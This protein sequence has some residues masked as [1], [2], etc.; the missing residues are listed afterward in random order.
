MFKM[1]IS[2]MM[3]MFFITGCKLAVDD[4]K[5]DTD[6]STQGGLTDSNNYTE[7]QGQIYYQLDEIINAQE[8]D[9]MSG[10]EYKLL[11]LR[12]YLIGKSHV[13]RVYPDLDGN[14]FAY[15]VDAGSYQVVIKWTKTKYDDTGAEY[16]Y[17]AIKNIYVVA[18][19][20]TDAGIFY[21]NKTYMTTSE[22][23]SAI[24]DIDTAE[25]S[26][27][28]WAGDDATREELQKM[29]SDSLSQE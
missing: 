20:N 10:Y 26:N 25:I 6:T 1:I 28:V 9:T 17:M 4:T 24:E 8:D 14:F 23:T 12:I 11:D 16:T 15:N 21:V 13:F 5:S 29:Y 18:G 27:K 3:V 2:L 22:E 19:K 7:V